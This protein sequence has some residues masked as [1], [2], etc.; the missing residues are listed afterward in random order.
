MP[1][2]EV[3]RLGRHLKQCLHF[4]RLSTSNVCDVCYVKAS[5]KFPAFS[6]SSPSTFGFILSNLIVHY[7]KLQYKCTESRENDQVL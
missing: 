3:T 4:C 1:S 7:V 2:H 5:V 6:P